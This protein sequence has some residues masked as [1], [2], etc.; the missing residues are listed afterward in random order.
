MEFMGGFDWEGW[1]VLVVLGGQGWGKIYQYQKHMNLLPNG[2]EPH[3]RTLGFLM[4]S[5]ETI[6][7]KI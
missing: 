2:S 3:L 6:R 7:L 4:L 5:G 1:S